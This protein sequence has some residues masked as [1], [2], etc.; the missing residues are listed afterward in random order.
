MP[1]ACLYWHQLAF[2]SQLQLAKLHPLVSRSRCH[3]CKQQI[4]QRGCSKRDELMAR[5]AIAHSIDWYRTC[6]F[7]SAQ[8]HSD[9]VAAWMPSTISHAAMMLMSSRSLMILRMSETSRSTVER[10][11]AN[12]RKTIMDLLDINITIECETVDGMLAAVQV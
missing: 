8:S 6:Q 11:V 9:T 12:R 1:A 10:Y 5:A 7:T 2:I 3:C 4:C